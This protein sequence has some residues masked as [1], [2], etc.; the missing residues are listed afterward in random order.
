MPCGVYISLDHCKWTLHDPFFANIPDVYKLN[1]MLTLP[2]T[3]KLF[4]YAR[5]IFPS[6]T[7]T[8]NLYYNLYCA[9]K[10]GRFRNA[11]DWKLG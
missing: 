1:I 2:V 6:V 3:V 4:T 9:R 5:P 7:A 11:K 8:V 10:D